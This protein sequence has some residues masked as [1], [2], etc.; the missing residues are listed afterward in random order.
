D[1]LPIL[2]DQH[3]LALDRCLAW[4]QWLPMAMLHR[5]LVID[6]TEHLPEPAIAVRRQVRTLV[7]VG[8]H[9]ADQ[10]PVRLFPGQFP[11]RHADRERAVL[12]RGF[13]V[14][15]VAEKSRHLLLA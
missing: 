11:L 15:L 10:E 12:D 2:V 6:L 3:L 1:A 5:Y 7:H 14:G 13:G 4:R 9:R 8:V